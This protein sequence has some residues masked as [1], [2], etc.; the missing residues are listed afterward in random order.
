MRSFLEALYLFDIKSKCVHTPLDLFTPLVYSATPRA[1][2]IYLSTL[3]NRSKGLF[4]WG[5]T[6][7]LSCTPYASLHD[8]KNWYTV[9]A[10]FFVHRPA[11]P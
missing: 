1:S 6:S 9:Y 8:Q 10:F 4:Y 7:S 2:E 5:T 3:Y 11:I